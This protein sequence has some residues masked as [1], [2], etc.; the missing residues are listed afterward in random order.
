LWC[1]E[2]TDVADGFPQ[3]VDCAGF[4]FSEMGFEFGVRHLDWGK[5]WAV[6]RQE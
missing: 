6:W 5:V 1:E 3:V 2:F 4:Y